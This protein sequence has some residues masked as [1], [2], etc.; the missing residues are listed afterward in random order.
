MGL[1]TVAVAVCALAIVAACLGLF[2]SHISVVIALFVVAL[3]AAIV[4][5]VPD[6]RVIGGWLA[7]SA[8]VSIASLA[9]TY[10]MPPRSPVVTWPMIGIIGTVMFGVLLWLVMSDGLGTETA[11]AP[12]A[13]VVRRSPRIG[14]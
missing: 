1:R 5:V 9:S 12:T 10:S 8:L 6:R 7:S 4:V 13:R 14:N 3:G 11:S 2:A